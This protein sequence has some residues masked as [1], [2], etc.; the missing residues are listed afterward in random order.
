MKFYG[1]KWKL[2]Q[3]EDDWRLPSCAQETVKWLAYRQKHKKVEY[4]AVGLLYY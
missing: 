4:D 1:E 3:E 2:R